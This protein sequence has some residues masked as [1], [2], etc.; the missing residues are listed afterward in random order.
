MTYGFNIEKSRISR[1]NTYK[2][3]KQ[4]YP[5]YE[6]KFT[7]R[8]ITQKNN[9][10]LNTLRNTTQKKQFGGFT[11]GYG[12]SNFGDRLA[13]L[14][15]SEH[16]RASDRSARLKAVRN[17]D[18]YSKRSNDSV[19]FIINENT[20][21]SDITIRNIENSSHQRVIQEDALVRERE[22]LGINVTPSEVSRYLDPINFDN[23]TGSQL[24]LVRMAM[25]TEES[26]QIASY[27][28]S[29]VQGILSLLGDQTS[30]GSPIGFSSGPDSGPSFGPNSDHSGEIRALTA[31][32]EQVL[33][34]VQTASINAFKYQ[35]D[36]TRFSNNLDILTRTTVIPLVD[37]INTVSQKIVNDI[38]VI[39]TTADS[40]V[41]SIASVNKIISDS[42]KEFTTLFSRFTEATGIISTT[43]ASIDT[44]NAYNNY[45]TS[46]T[47][48]ANSISPPQYTNPTYMNII[49]N[50]ISVKISPMVTDL[51]VRYNSID[52]VKQDAQVQ[53][54]TASEVIK[55][56][57]GQKQQAISD[58]LQK[59]PNGLSEADITSYRTAIHN[60]ENALNTFNRDTTESLQLTSGLRQPNNYENLDS[61]KQAVETANELLN[62]PIT[63][64][65]ALLYSVRPESL[66]PSDP[67]PVLELPVNLNPTNLDPNTLISSER[68]K[69]DIPLNILDHTKIFL[70]SIAGLLKGAKTSQDSS[71]DSYDGI[72]VTDS[73]TNEPI[74]KIQTEIAVAGYNYN[75]IVSNLLENVS[76]G[77]RTLYNLSKGQNASKKS[78]QT[79]NKK[80]AYKNAG[81]AKPPILVRV[82]S[83]TTD[84]S[85]KELRLANT[86]SDLL[87]KKFLLESYKSLVVIF[88]GNNSLPETDRSNNLKNILIPA[89]TITIEATDT[90]I[91]SLVKKVNN[92][93]QSVTPLTL[94]EPVKV[95]DPTEDLE[96][97]KSILT[98]DIALLT[99]HKADIDS[100]YRSKF[101]RSGESTILFAKQADSS[102]DV[103]LN[104]TAKSQFNSTKKY[105]YNQSSS[106]K[107]VYA[108]R[109]GAVRVIQ[110]LVART[111]L[112]IINEQSLLANIQNTLLE[113]DY[114]TKNFAFDSGTEI[115]KL[116]RLLYVK[117]IID[118]EK[119]IATINI[120]ISNIS[121]SLHP[122]VPNSVNLAN[123]YLKM[124]P[125]QKAYDAA[126]DSVTKY[127]NDILN[128]ELQIVSNIR[129]KVELTFNFFIKR[130]RGDISALQ[131][132]YSNSKTAKQTLQRGKVVLTNTKYSSAAYVKEHPAFNLDGI[133]STIRSIVSKIT[134]ISTKEESLQ[135]FQSNLNSLSKNT[136]KYDSILG[137]RLVKERDSLEAN[138]ES[139]RTTIRNN[140][141]NI[142]TKSVV[143][144]QSPPQAFTEPAPVLPDNSTLN[145]ERSN[146]RNLNGN[147]NSVN[148]D[149]SYYK[150]IIMIFEAFKIRYVE[151]FTLFTQQ[152]IKDNYSESYATEKA[153]A[154]VN[155][156]EGLTAAKSIKDALPIS[157]KDKIIA[158]SKSNSDKEEL[159][160]KILEDIK[161]LN[162]M[163]NN[164]KK[165]A[166][167]DKLG[168]LSDSH[169]KL[170]EL[171]KYKNE[172]EFQ[173]E[174]I[175]GL[176]SKIEELL[177]DSRLT[178]KDL[179]KLRDELAKLRDE[180]ALKEKERKEIKDLIEKLEKMLRALDEDIKKLKDIRK[181]EDKISKPEKS[182]I[183]KFAPY[184]PIVGFVGLASFGVLF[185]PTPAPKNPPMRTTTSSSENGCNEG[186]KQGAKDGDSAGFNAGLAE[187]NRQY[188][189]W[190]QQ[191]S[192][193]IGPDNS[194]NDDSNS[195]STTTT[196]SI[197]NSN[198]NN[199][200]TNDSNTNAKTTLTA[201]YLI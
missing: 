102:S 98:L 192:L 2:K 106:F 70:E 42:V 85:N 64:L 190:M 110:G 92:P 118:T 188:N 128:I 19:K 136:S 13:S 125:T 54:D 52:G 139:L 189:L 142:N 178:E 157:I 62:N 81:D 108:R 199:N 30:Q 167:F 91:N 74:A 8:N 1:S 100:Q 185:N 12:S 138:I 90:S 24:A 151:R 79:K 49:R 15:L 165:Y 137:V 169:S 32:I 38:Y 29:F 198:S 53:L 96:T 73:P 3:I 141:Q 77:F 156:V 184:M 159:I 176:I 14:A 180:L 10:N 126:K 9:T 45:L 127:N 105:W 149:L 120:N 63:G 193:P 146:L 182:L 58:F 36:F 135:T 143:E 115:S 75:S 181:P 25:I 116:A 40:L 88:S 191:Y 48:Y 86:Q 18:G 160:S 152:A 66:P 179:K 200:S 50:S 35:G 20:S 132:S 162:D 60:Y 99:K 41:E 140:L 46:L 154:H 124:V 122:L 11:R 183:S 113:I 89:L 107:D 44:T 5:L 175:K 103:K 4:T 109:Y 172:N 33:L 17:K 22:V 155:K 174:K 161:L 37:S 111:G 26:R 166:V 186:T 78:E 83:N 97:A 87:S 194:S 39:Y 47:K 117:G 55:N 95:A 195:I 21:A 145:T 6:P 196:G 67:I 134:Q 101:F 187:A 112:R 171:I 65:N 170:L 129:V 16:M 61:L 131:T 163:L 147:M 133:K 34:T 51:I 121:N 76:V 27:N 71:K 173:I 148:D 164:S 7:I 68:A 114:V 69:L 80:T 56:I 28:K 59:I 168:K 177:K 84:V 144:S 119:D 82:P 57:P 123:S 94:T 150:R 43:P 23:S 72:T 130:N 158:D 93:P 104:L 153:N 31:A 197:S 201:K